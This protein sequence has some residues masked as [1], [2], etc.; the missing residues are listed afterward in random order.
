MGPAMIRSGNLLANARTNLPPDEAITTLAEL[1]GARIERMSSAILIAFR[2][3]EF[4]STHPQRL[5]HRVCRVGVE[6][7]LELGEQLARNGRDVFHARHREQQPLSAS[8][9]GDL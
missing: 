9:E 1:P 7:R 3:N 2:S 5:E 8:V 4:L 6:S